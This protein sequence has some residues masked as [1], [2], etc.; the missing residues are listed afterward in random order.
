[1]KTTS[2]LDRLIACFL[3]MLGTLLTIAPTP[4]NLRIAEYPRSS[5]KEGREDTCDVFAVDHETIQPYD[6]AC[7]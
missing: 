1:M 7:R 6:P 4:C 5:Q 3:L 2:C